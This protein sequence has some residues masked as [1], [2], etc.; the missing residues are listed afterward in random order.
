MSSSPSGPTSTVDGHAPDPAADDGGASGLTCD[1]PGSGN[2]TWPAPDG[3]RRATL[4]VQA[5]N[6]AGLCSEASAAGTADPRRVTISQEARRPPSSECSDASCRWLNVDVRNF[7][8]NADVRFQ[9]SDSRPD[10]YG[11]VRHCVGTNGSGSYDHRQHYYFGSPD[12]RCGDR[13]TARGSNLDRRGDGIWEPRT[14]TIQRHPMCSRIVAGCA[15]GVTPRPTPVRSTPTTAAARR[16]LPACAAT[17]HP[18][19]TE[20]QVLLIE[21]RSIADIN[22]RE[23]M[24]VR[25]SQRRGLL[26]SPQTRGQ[27]RFQDDDSRSR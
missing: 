14:R 27:L 22:L 24:P 12:D 15:S 8:P 2:Y 18:G 16:L 9:P 23:R 19:P 26:A 4:T 6:A 21:G 11:S 17:R 3:A 1:V 13:S 20:R 25:L 10:S 5:C 7:P